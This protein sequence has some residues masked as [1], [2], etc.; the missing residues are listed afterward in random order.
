MN[1]LGYDRQHP[2]NFSDS[3]A[4][5]IPWTAAR[6]NRLLRPLSSKIALLRKESQLEPESNATRCA[7]NPIAVSSGSGGSVGCHRRSAQAAADADAEWQSNP[8]PRKK[9]KR[10][11]SAKARILSL[12]DTEY[13]GIEAQACHLTSEAVIELPFQLT[14]ETRPSERSVTIED[15]GQCPKPVPAQHLRVPSQEFPK[16][17]APNTWKLIDGIGKGSMA[18]LNATDYGNPPLLSG[19]RSLFSTCLRQTPKYIAKEEHQADVDDQDGDVDISSA[20]YSDLEEFGS[21]P[22]GGWEPLREVARA[23]GISMVTDAIEDG[24]LG[25]PVARHL[26]YLFL[27]VGAYDEAQRIIESLTT[28]VTPA[29]QLVSNKVRRLPHDL[30]MIVNNLDSLASRSGRDG[31]LFRHIAVMLDRGTLPTNWISGKPMVGTWNKAI[32][33][34]AQEDEYAPSAAVL[35]HTAVAMSYREAD[36]TP[37]NVHDMRLDIHVPPHRP[38]L[39]SD[40]LSQTSESTVRSQRS[41]EISSR[42]KSKE[43]DSDISTTLSNLLTVLVAITR[44]RIPA[45]LSYTG[46]CNTW[47]TNVLYDLS[48]GARRAVDSMMQDSRLK[49]LMKLHADSLRLP[50]LAAGLAELSNRRCSSHVL[51]PQFPWLSNLAS[52]SPSNEAI[53]LAS[54]FICGVARCCG[55]AR[56]EDPFE[57]VQSIVRDL[58]EASKLIYNDGQTRKIC[59]DV[60]LGAAFAYSEDTSRP[61]HLD[62]ALQV[63]LDITG[64][65]ASTPIHS[66][67]RTPARSKRNSRSEYRWEEGI[68]EWIA[69]TPDLLLHKRTDVRADN[70]GMGERV[71]HMKR[72][73]GGRPPGLP[74]KSPCAAIKKPVKVGSK[75]RRDESKALHVLIK[76]KFNS[77]SRGR[78]ADQL[79]SVSTCQ[80]SK[81][82]HSLKSFSRIYEDN[83]CDELSIPC[84][85]QKDTLALSTLQELPNSV[86]G[87]K[88]KRRFGHTYNAYGLKDS[89]PTSST[90]QLSRN[91]ERHQRLDMAEDELAAPSG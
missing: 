76:A 83:D 79:S 31:F 22:G 25:L 5:K 74:E 52:L 24:V 68:C 44:L 91:S 28:L 61:N 9:I 50:L 40:S 26:F 37:S 41:I 59:S 49:G 54:S 85:S 39:R 56:S 63:E 11:Y 36:A 14:V 87:V 15:N 16:E 82:A 29:N 62:W 78:K 1:E 66:L 10:T 90:M 27:D 32:R 71:E 65:T 43:S 58:I 30:H 47:I 2:P 13:N 45:G 33:S 75:L 19:C 77:Y 89:I 7:T 55:R 4:S 35:L 53:S 17:L 20:V 21:M 69:M 67:V 34:I 64:K 8:R 70:D 48:L 60:A 81:K 88:P 18:L 86:F 72:T 57:I 23:H 84:T 12:R 80:R 38:V 46:S 73:L 3:A 51:Q 6:C 42:S